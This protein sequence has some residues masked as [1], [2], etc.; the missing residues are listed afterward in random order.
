[1]IQIVPITALE[2]FLVRHPV[3]RNG[4][5]IESCHFDGDDLASTKHF[6]LFDNGVLAGVISVFEQLFAAFANEK[7]FQIRGMAV[8]E[9]FRKRGFGERLVLEVEQYV[10]AQNGQLIWFNA[11]ENAVKFYSNLG[12]QIIGDAYDIKDIGLHY[13]MFKNLNEI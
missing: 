5:P 2:T 3:L 7:Q 6:G 11:R 10:R 9:H 4:K 8:L 1:M 12:Y 13:R